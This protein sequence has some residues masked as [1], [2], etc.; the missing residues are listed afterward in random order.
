VSNRDWSSDVCSSDLG[1]Q[2]VR[3]ARQAQTKRRR[4]KLLTHQGNN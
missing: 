3:E 1:M 4:P 2:G